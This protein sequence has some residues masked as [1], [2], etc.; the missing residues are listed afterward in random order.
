VEDFKHI[1]ETLKKMSY[2]ADSLELWAKKN[3]YI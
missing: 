1:I 2:S 3:G